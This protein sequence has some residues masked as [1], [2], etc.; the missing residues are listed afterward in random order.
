MQVLDGRMLQAP[1]AAA[2]EL[3]WICGNRVEWEEDKRKEMMTLI[4]N[5]IHDDDTR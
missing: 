2:S 4:E 1:F 5:D 3:L